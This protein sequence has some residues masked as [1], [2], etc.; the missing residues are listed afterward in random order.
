VEAAGIEPAAAYHANLLMAR[1]GTS[2]DGVVRDVTEVLGE[3][4]GI[5]ADEDDDFSVFD[6][7]EI[8]EALRLE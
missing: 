5:G 2:I 3:R 8:A 4:R 6:T 1:D 7:K